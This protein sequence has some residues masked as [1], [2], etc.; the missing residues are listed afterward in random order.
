LT[1]SGRGYNFDVLRAKALLRYGEVRRVFVK[2]KPGFEHLVR[3]H[4]GHGIDLSTF[5]A[6]LRAGRFW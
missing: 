4:M 6:D 5:E 2:A 3:G 1:R